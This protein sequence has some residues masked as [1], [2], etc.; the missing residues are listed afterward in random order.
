MSLRRDTYAHTRSKWDTGVGT[1]KGYVFFRRLFLFR[2][3]G[4]QGSIF[5]GYKGYVKGLGYRAQVTFFWGPG[6]RVRF[7]WG[8][9]RAKHL[10]YYKRTNQTVY[11]MVTEKKKTNKQNKKIKRKAFKK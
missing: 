7:F 4:K 2:Q 8:T 6:Y 3:Q 9:S 1:K 5:L 11:E 10:E